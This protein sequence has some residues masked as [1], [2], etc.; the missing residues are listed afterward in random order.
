MAGANVPG[1][2]VLVVCLVSSGAVLGGGGGLRG[3]RVARVGPADVGADGASRA[4][5]VIAV[6]EVVVVGQRRGVMV[7][8]LDQRGTAGPAADHL[9]RQRGPVTGVLRSVCSSGG[10]VHELPEALDVLFELTEDQVGA[11]AAEVD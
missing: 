8:Y 7:R 2:V 10:G 9:G 11:V 3:Q 1:G 5:R 4:A 6:G